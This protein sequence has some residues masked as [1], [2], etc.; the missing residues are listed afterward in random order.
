MAL[1]D[2][3]ILAPDNEFDRSIVLEEI[4]TSTGVRTPIT[5]GTITGFLSTGYDST[6]TA[7]HASLSVSGVYIGGQLKVTGGTATYDAGTWLFHIDASVLTKTLLDTYFATA[8]PYFI[9]TKS[10]SLRKVGQL[11]Y[12]TYSAG[13]TEA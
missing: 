4:N 8:T 1:P 11:T 12:L 9:V 10:S 2:L 6:A 7:A 5:T 13:G 3:G